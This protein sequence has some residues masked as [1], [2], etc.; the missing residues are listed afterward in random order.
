MGAAGLLQE[1]ARRCVDGADAFAGHAHLNIEDRV[2]VELAAVAL[3]DGFGGLK[4][5]TGVLAMVY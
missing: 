1:P 4:L 2:A 5:H 3:G